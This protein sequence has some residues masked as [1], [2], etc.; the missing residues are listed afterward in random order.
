MVL[1]WTSVGS[2]NVDIGANPSAEEAE[3]GVDDSARKVVDIIDSF[4]LVV[5]G[6]SFGF[7]SSSS[8]ASSLIFGAH[9]TPHGSDMHA[10]VQEQPTFDKKAFLG[11]AKVHSCCSPRCLPSWARGGVESC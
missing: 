1:Q 7:C 6:C 9:T 5:R 3:E 10:C 11:W 2:V 4:R 8:T